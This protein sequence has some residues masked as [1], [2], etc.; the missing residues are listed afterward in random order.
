[1]AAV[2]PLTARRPSGPLAGRADV[3]GDE[4][5][6]HQTLIFGALAV[7]RTQICGLLED[8]DVW[9]TVA[10]MRALGVVVEKKDTAW[11]VTGCGI[12]G[13]VEP[14][15][16]LD[17]GSSEMTAWLLAGLLASH[18][19]HA[20]IT[21]G[22]SLRRRSMHQITELLAL[23]GAQFAGRKGGCLPLSIQGAADA[24][25]VRCRIPGAL[26]QAKSAVLLAGLNARGQTEIREAVATPD[27]TENMLRHFGATVS[28]E[29]DG[30]SRIIALAGQPELRGREVMVP[31]DLS[32]AAFPLVAALLI[33]DSAITLAG[34]GLNP[35]R[36][37]LLTTLCE[38]GAD[39]KI[40]AERIEAGE[41]VGDLLVR[42]CTLSAIDASPMRAPTITDNYPLLAVAA[43]FARGTTRMAG[44]ADSVAKGSN[45][46]GQTATM[47]QA[48]GVRIAIDGDDLLVHGT[49]RVPGGCMVQPGTDHRLAMSALVMGQATDAPVVVGN[50]AC[51]DASFSGFVA[52]MSGLG[53]NIA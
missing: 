37:G 43:A 10:A 18:D 49:G 3:P 24:L 51:I 27:H 12:G 34:I 9:R 6:S 15:E 48:A 7:G 33:P 35:L 13:L 36:I 53:A 25:P 2:H 5:I 44:M 4:A 46:L 31:G 22:A 50:A 19:M 41:P 47:L 16:V 21:G 17:T 1:M 28:V 11:H 52:L 14:E 30:A 39:I 40:I 23:C 45:R 26:T 32:L 20:V 8:K 42:H 38:M 29:A